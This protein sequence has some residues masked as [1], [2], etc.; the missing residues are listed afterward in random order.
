MANKGVRQLGTIFVETHRIPWSFRV[1]KQVD[2][3]STLNSRLIKNQS[4]YT[5]RIRNKM[6]QHD[7]ATIII[8][9]RTR[10]KNSLFFDQS[11]AQYQSSPSVSFWQ[12][13]QSKPDRQFS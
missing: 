3:T 2:T 5:G 13:V 4:S 6:K 10:D 8:R 9:N 7:L 12:E 11:S 1:V